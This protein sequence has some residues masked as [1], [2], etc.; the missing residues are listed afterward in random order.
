MLYF[1]KAA[2]GRAFR[3]S[4]NDVGDKRVNVASWDALLYFASL[5]VTQAV[6]RIT[7]QG[8]LLF[9]NPTFSFKT[10]LPA[11]SW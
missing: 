8:N 11:K 3:A 6:Q 1:A 5:F 9:T 2:H 4:A 7:Y 10:S